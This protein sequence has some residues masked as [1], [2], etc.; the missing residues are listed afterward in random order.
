MAIPWKTIE[1]VDTK[2]GVLELRRHGQGDF[3]IT[4]DG[5]VLMNSASHRTEAAL[6]RLACRHLETRPAPRVLVGGLGMGF[7]LRAVL[8]ALPAGAE[9]TV[10]E[11][12]PVVVSWCRGPLSELTGGAAVDPRVRIEIEDVARVVGNRAEKPGPGTIDA[13]IYDLY[14]G[15]YTR[16]HKEG[17]P[18]Y[19]NRAIESVRTVLSPGGI[20]A[21]WGE[22]YD[23]GFVK[24]LEAGGFEATVRRPKK[25]GPRHVIYLAKPQPSRHNIG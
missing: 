17:D 18:L 2:E 21:V 1:S 11:L 23:A 10:A 13:V 14:T 15:P 8:D 9:V 6:G 20:F 19:G 24:R 3:L 12:N 5:R 22:D 4:V 25:G 7:T 16:T